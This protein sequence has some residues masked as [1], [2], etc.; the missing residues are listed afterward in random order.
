MP[1][2]ALHVPRLLRQIPVQIKADGARL[3][4]LQVANHRRHIC[5]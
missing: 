3:I 5:I 4:F 1:A 2:S